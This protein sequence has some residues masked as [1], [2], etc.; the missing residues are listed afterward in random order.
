MYGTN[1]YYN[2]A[3]WNQSTQLFP[4]RL[5]KAQHRTK[6]YMLTCFFRDW[7]AQLHP[8]CVCVC[9]CVC[10]GVCESEWDWHTCSLEIIG[11][12]YIFHLY[13]LKG[14]CNNS[15]CAMW[16]NI[17]LGSSL[18]PRLFIAHGKES[19]EMRIQ[20]WFPMYVLD[21]LWCLCCDAC[22]RSLFALAL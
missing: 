13:W 21:V 19:G 12:Q 2:V 3:K 22:T 1:N 9:V 5:I 14:V 15:Y 8:A 16:K 6:T 10:N 20:V 7:T 18:M 11:S 17:T 4:W